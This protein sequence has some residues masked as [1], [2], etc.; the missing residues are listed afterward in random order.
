MGDRKRK[1][2]KDIENGDQ[3]LAS[4]LRI[5][6]GGLGLGRTALALLSHYRGMGKIVGLC[7]GAVAME[8]REAL[9]EGAS[10]GI[11]IRKI[12]IYKKRNAILGIK[13]MWK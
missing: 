2:K 12:D 9:A 3:I 11:C 7:G 6:T 1:S 10:N 8:K 5:G 13:E 4:V